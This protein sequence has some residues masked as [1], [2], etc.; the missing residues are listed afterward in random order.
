MP[1][2]KDGSFL[3]LMAITSLRGPQ[4]RSALVNCCGRSQDELGD[5][6]ISLFGLMRCHLHM[7]QSHLNVLRWPW[8][9]ASRSHG[10]LLIYFILRVTCVRAFSMPTEYG[11]V[12]RTSPEGWRYGSSRRHRVTSYMLCIAWVRAFKAPVGVSRLGFPSAREV[13]RA[14][15][16]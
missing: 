2:V 7:C 13:L 16:W 3:S 6:R 14:C 12:N 10:L 15:E 9:R 11:G 5:E 8:C 1:N 4:Q